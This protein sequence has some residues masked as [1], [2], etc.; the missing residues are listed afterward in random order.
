MQLGVIVILKFP[1]IRVWYRYNLFTSE[2]ANTMQLSCA[3]ITNVIMLVFSF[4]GISW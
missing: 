4:Q 1:K 3:L 2:R